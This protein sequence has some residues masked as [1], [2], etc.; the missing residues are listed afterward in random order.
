[1][2]NLNQLLEEINK[3]YRTYF[4]PIK[5]GDK[6]LYFLQIADMKKHIEKSIEKGAGIEFLYW[7]KIWESSVIL[8]YM[9]SKKNQAPVE[10]TKTC[11]EIGAG[12][13]VAGLFAA[14]FGYDVTITDINKDALLFAKISA[15]KNGLNVKIKKVDFTKDNLNNQYDVILASEVLYNKRD[16]HHLIKFFKQHIK[17]SGII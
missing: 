6:E 9:L 13:G 15:L 7:A 4:E 3:K 14:T 2:E 12:I 11:L 8:A 17:N 10:R 16:Y 5:I 1:M